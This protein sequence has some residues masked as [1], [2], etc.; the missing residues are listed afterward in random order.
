MKLSSRVTYR[1]V[2]RTDALDRLVRARM[3][4]LERASGAILRCDVVVERSHRAHRHG[5]VFHVRI[6]MT[7][8]GA[9]VIV[10][11]DA[12]RDPAHEDVLVAVRDAFRRARAD[13]ASLTTRA[14]TLAARGPTR[15]PA[16]VPA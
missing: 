3:A 10:G 16:R 12:E 4:R 2:N 5:N 8:P 9:E 1:N 7:I 14:R 13:L 15:G 6:R 11:R